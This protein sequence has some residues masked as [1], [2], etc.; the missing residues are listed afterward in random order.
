MSEYHL[1][2]KQVDV[3]NKLQEIMTSTD[4]CECYR[5]KNWVTLRRKYEFIC[6]YFN[7]RVFKEFD[8]KHL[9]DL[10]LWLHN[11]GYSVEVNVNSKILL[12]FR[13]T[14]TDGLEHEGTI[15]QNGAGNLLAH[16]VCEFFSP[17][18]VYKD[19]D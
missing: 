5:V 8:S 13:K 4:Y 12:R 19:E 2:R 1:E 18:G 10:A 7:R 17:Y 6:D 15:Y 11:I 9:K 16:E 3:P 14:L